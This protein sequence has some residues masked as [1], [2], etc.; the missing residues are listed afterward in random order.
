MP[1]AGVISQ[2]VP[3][4]S[5]ER[6]EVR[7]TVTDIRWAT[8]RVSRQA[9]P[10]DPPGRLMP[11]S[12]SGLDRGTGLAIEPAAFA[13]PEVDRLGHEAPT[14]RPSLRVTAMLPSI[15]GV[16]CEPT[17]TGQEIGRPS[18][19]H[20]SPVASKSATARCACIIFVSSAHGSSP[21]AAT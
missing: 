15:T 2:M 11:I 14:T 6:Y 3:D 12:L 10:G 21:S 16:R 20:T 1:R 17:V 5:L 8:G 13:A 19:S 4:V 9:W 18:P 7:L